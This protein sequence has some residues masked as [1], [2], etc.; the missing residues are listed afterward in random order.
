MKI[1]IKTNM[2]SHVNRNDNFKVLIFLQ[3]AER[4]SKT[5]SVL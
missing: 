2:T 4:K 3:A 1:L 5:I